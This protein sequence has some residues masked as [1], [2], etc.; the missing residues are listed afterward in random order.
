MIILLQNPVTL[1]KVPLNPR[2]VTESRLHLVLP[3]L[4]LLLGQATDVMNH[5][6]S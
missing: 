6:K 4:Q 1:V 3:E 5:V 2:I